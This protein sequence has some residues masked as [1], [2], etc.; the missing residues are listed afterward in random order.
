MKL[1]I[2]IGDLLDIFFH[3]SANSIGVTSSFFKPSNTTFPPL[4]DSFFSLLP[5]LPQRP[6][7]LHYGRFIGEKF[8]IFLH[9][10]SSIA[11]CQLDSQRPH[12]QCTKTGRRLHVLVPIF[13]SNTL[14]ICWFQL[15]MARQPHSLH[16]T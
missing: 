12:Q 2:R 16:N 14:Y 5:F 6:Q 10:T 3:I 11:D 9:D 4:G 7:R 13:M 15:G 1:H 8:H